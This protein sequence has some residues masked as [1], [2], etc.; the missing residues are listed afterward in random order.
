MS[1][2]TEIENSTKN[3]IL[4]TPDIYDFRDT[5]NEELFGQFYEFC[6]E[7]LDS[8]FKLGSISQ[9]IFLFRNS[10]TINAM[11][12]FAK[13]FHVILINSGLMMNCIENYL[14][15]E[16]LDNYIIS[17]FLDITEK[18][19]NQISALAFQVTTQF[20]Y[21]HELAHLLQF[22]K[23][24]VESELQE[25]STA[26]ANF[27]LQKHKLEI[28]ADT[29][30]AISI[31]SHLEQYI[32]KMYGAEITETITNDIIKVLGACL[33]NYIVNFNDDTNIYFKEKTHPHPFLRTLNIILNI[34]THIEKMPYFKKHNI[35]LNGRE[36]FKNI[37]DFYQN[38]ED[39]GIFKTKFSDLV[40]KNTDFQKDIVE[41]LEELLIFDDTNFE[42]A[43]NIW[44]K[45]II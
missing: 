4:G 20:T 8:H 22:N 2:D 45:H 18:L 3:G 42:D 38:L 32:E 27:D 15:N 33:L 11:A 40:Y 41:Y 12:G 39:E 29:Y 35:E 6:R 14:K 26:E 28:N 31:A 44:N 1:Y 17:K 13:N 19:D 34:S 5:P 7:N 37:T 24:L 9:N 25:R 30:A 16:N 36:I 10:L 23:T 21:Y 43:M